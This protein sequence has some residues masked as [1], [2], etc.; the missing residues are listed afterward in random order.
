MVTR[1]QGH[2][3]TTFARSRAF[4][5][6]LLATLGGLA[7]ADNLRNTTRLGTITTDGYLATSSTVTSSGTNNVRQIRTVLRDPSGSLIWSKD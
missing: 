4:S 2:F 7:H 6:L 5:I 3:R 1:M